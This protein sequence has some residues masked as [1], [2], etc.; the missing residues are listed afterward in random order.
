MPIAA[1]PSAAAMIG[2]APS[3]NEKALRLPLLLPRRFS[4]ELLR[5]SLELFRPAGRPSV[6]V[7]IH[8]SL[9]RLSSKLGA[10]TD[11]E[12]PPFRS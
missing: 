8:S 5:F 6:R 3:P 12:E 11:R 1:P 4:L 9:S 7:A 10:S 2:P